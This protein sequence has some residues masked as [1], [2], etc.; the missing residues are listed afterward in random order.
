MVLEGKWEGQGGAPAQGVEAE[1]GPWREVGTP[2]C[3]GLSEGKGGMEGK[4]GRGDGRK[5]KGTPKEERKF[6]H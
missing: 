2:R 4:E 3:C 1:G 5:G 6:A